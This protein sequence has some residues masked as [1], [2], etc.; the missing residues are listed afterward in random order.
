MTAVVDTLELLYAGVETVRVHGMAAEA[1]AASAEPTMP[2]ASSVAKVAVPSAA[3]RPRERAHS[4]ILSMRV[5]LLC[6]GPRLRALSGVGGDRCRV[7]RN[8]RRGWNSSCV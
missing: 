2:V 4:I 7:T 8:Q 6:P 1:C 3:A 5:F